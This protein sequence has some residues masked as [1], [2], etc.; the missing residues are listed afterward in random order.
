MGSTSVSSRMRMEPS[1]RR[2]AMRLGKAKSWPS[3]AEN[4][5]FVDFF[6]NN[7]VIYARYK[8]VLYEGS[9]K[10]IPKLWKARQGKEPQPLVESVV[11]RE[12]LD[13]AS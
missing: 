5:V 10:S 11:D 2:R 13:F 9:G 8:G 1:T 3:A 7:W 12:C 6:H 4:G